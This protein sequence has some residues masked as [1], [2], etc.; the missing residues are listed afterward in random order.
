MLNDIHCDE[1]TAG[2]G[3]TGKMFAVEHENIKPD[4]TCVSK[5]ITGGYVPL[6]VTAT[7]EIY[8]ALGKYGE[9]KTFSGILV[10]QIRLQSLPQI[11][12]LTY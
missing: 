4:F 6:V 3:R 12:F 11:K 8:N 5:G 10:P 7:N 2:F 1:V 9:F